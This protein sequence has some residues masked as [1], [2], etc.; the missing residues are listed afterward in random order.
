LPAGFLLQN[1]IEL[2]ENKEG[3]IFEILNFSEY[4]SIHRPTACKAISSTDAETEAGAKAFP[5][6]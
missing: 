6:C 2:L 4:W 5:S 3:K 1:H